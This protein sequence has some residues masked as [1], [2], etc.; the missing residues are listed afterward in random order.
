[1]RLPIMPAMLLLVA[2]GLLYVIYQG[3]EH[4]V[5][6]PRRLAKAPAMAA[7]AAIPVAADTVDESA[8]SDECQVI[9]QAAQTAQRAVQSGESLETL[10][11]RP[12]IA[13]QEDPALRAKLQEVAR[14]VY[15]APPQAARWQAILRGQHCLPGERS[16]RLSR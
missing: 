9:A 14:A 2:A 5:A 15:A 6:Q 10:L 13:W 16:G 11:R 12:V 3:S 7:P 1:M 4:L 8:L